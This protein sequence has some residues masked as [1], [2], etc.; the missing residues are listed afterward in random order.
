[1]NNL[2]CSNPE[3]ICF[4]GVG[5]NLNNPIRQIKNALGALSNHSK[6]KLLKTSSFYKS[7]ALEFSNQPDYINCVIS[8]ETELTPYDLLSSLQ[9]IEKKQGRVRKKKWGSRTIDLDIL[10]YGDVKV[11]DQELTIPHPEIYKRHFVVYPLA[12]ISNNLIFPDNLH[13]NQIISKC[14]I[15][16]LKKIDDT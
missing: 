14:P 5:S 6:I 11:S 7:K 13:I 10:L 15:N 4:I 3:T 12:E 9:E 1:M 2:D 16:E 8:I